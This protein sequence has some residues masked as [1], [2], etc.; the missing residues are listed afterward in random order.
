MNKYY[1]IGN[2]CFQVSIRLLL[3][4]RKLLKL[5]RIEQNKASFQIGVDYWIIDDFQVVL[6]FFFI[7]EVVSSLEQQQMDTHSKGVA[8][9]IPAMSPS[10]QTDTIQYAAQYPDTHIQNLPWMLLGASVHGCLANIRLNFVMHVI[11]LIFC[12]LNFAQKCLHHG[13][14]VFQLQSNSINTL[15]CLSVCESQFFC[16]LIGQN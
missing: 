6:N 4:I 14:T 15:M 11:F 12:F 3:T 16:D 7:F 10:E 1:F 5:C 2:H 8:P 13:P 9:A